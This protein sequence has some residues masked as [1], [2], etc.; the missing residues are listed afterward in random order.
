L[1]AAC[2][3]ACER[4]DQTSPADLMWAILMGDGCVIACFEESGVAAPVLRVLLTEAE[5]FQR[6][7]G[8]AYPSV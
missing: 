8:G 4:G 1:N 7:A 3:R 5:R 2:N 6:M